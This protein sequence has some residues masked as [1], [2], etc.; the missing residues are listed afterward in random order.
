MNTVCRASIV[1]VVL[2]AAA[3]AG[4]AQPT[5][6]I[7]D[8]VPPG[9]PITQG[10]SEQ[11]QYQIGGT[12]NIV[13]VT[14]VRDDG[15]TVSIAN[16]D[17]TS[18][19]PFLIDLPM[20]TGVDRVTV[21]WIGTV[22]DTVTGE[23]AAGNRAATIVVDNV[24]PDPVNITSPS[25]PHTSYSATIELQG[26]ASNNPPAGGNTDLAETGGYLV[27]YV[28]ATGQ[29]VGGGIIRQDSTFLATVDMTGLTSDTMYTFNIHAVD[30][31]G[32]LGTTST[33]QLEYRLPP[34]PA[35]TNVTI[36]PPA[37]TLTNNPGVTVRG[38]VTGQ[39]P[40]FTVNVFV[41]GFI[42]SQI[43][44]LASGESFNHTLTLPGEGPHTISIQATNS[45][46][47][48]AVT[49]AQT[50]GTIT[51]DR[52]PPGAPTILSPD[53]NQSPYV[54][55]AATFTIRGIAA[56]R[57]SNTADAYTPAMLLAGPSGITFNPASPLPLNADGSFETVANLQNLG[58]GT[59]TITVTARD[60]AGNT[61]PQS[62][63][64]IV[65]VRD[66]TAPLV[67][68]IRV[69][70]VVAPQTNPEIYVGQR[71]VRVSV[72]VN[73]DMPTTPSST[74]TQTG[75]ST[76]PTGLSSSTLRFFD[77][78]Y[79][80]IPGH[81]GPVD[82][83]LSGG[84]DRAGNALT[85]S[86]PRLFIV[87]TVAPTVVSVTPTEGTS[88]SVSPDRIRIR[89][90]DPL[91][92]SN[93]ASGM[94]LASC[95]VTMSG[96]VGGSNAVVA[97][98][99]VPYDPVTLDFVP[100][101]P[102]VEEGVYRLAITAVDKV[103]NRSSTVTRT[104][105]F[106]T[107]PIRLT[108]QT[109]VTN[110]ADGAYVNAVT[111]PGTAASPFVEAFINDPQFNPATS[112]IRSRD[113]CRVPVDVPGTKTTTGPTNLTW[114]FKNPLATDGSQDGVYTIELDVKDFAG[115]LAP[116]YVTTYTY[117]T[118]VPAVSATFPANRE[119]VR[120]PLRIVDATM[121][122]PRVDFC[123]RN[124]GIDRTQ[125]LLDLWLTTP[126][127]YSGNTTTAPYQVPGTLRFI[128]VGDV[129]RV[130]LEIVNAQGNVTGLPTDGT[131]DGTYELR[132][133][134]VDRSGNRSGLTSVT[135][136]YDTQAPRMTVDALT[137][138]CTI[139]APLVEFGGTAQDNRGGSG[140]NR[141]EVSL[142]QVD[143]QGFPTQTPAYFDKLRAT[144]APL[145]LGP[146][147]P[148]PPQRTWTFS[149]ALSGL[150]TSTR[151][152]LLVRAFDEGGSFAEKRYI[153]T[154]LPS[155]LPAPQLSAP[156]AEASTSAQTVTFS[157][158]RVEGAG[159]Y[160]VR[161]TTPN[162]NEILKDTLKDVLSVSVNLAAWADG[163]GR[164]TW[165]VASK[166]C[167]G[168]VGAWSKN[169]V[170]V[171]DR[172]QPRVVAI[173]V[174]DPSPEAAGTVNEG[175]VR[176]TIRFTEPM[177]TTRPLT[178]I[179]A[180]QNSTAPA[181]TVTPMSFIGDTWTGRVIIPDAGTTGPDYNGLS[182][183]SVTG[184]RD[185]GGNAMLPPQEGFTVVEIDTGPF[186]KLAMFVNPI[187]EQ[188]VILVVKGTS[189]L[190]GPTERLVEPLTVIVR[191]TGQ[192][193][194]MPS[195][196]RIGPGA[197]RG[198]FFL[199]P[200]LAT[201]LEVQISGKDEQGNTSTRT[202]KLTVSRITVA[203]GGVVINQSRSMIVT[204][205]PGAVTQDKSIFLASASE[206]LADGAGNQ[207]GEGTAGELVMLA[208]LG[209]VEPQ[210]VAIPGG[211]DLLVD[212]NAVAPGTTDEI[213]RRAGLYRLD[214]DRWRWL[215]GRLDGA[216][217]TGRLDRTA[218]LAVMADTVAPRVVGLGEGAELRVARGEKLVVAVTDDGSGVDPLAVGATVDGRPVEAT[219]DAEAGALVVAPGSLTSGG[220]SLEVRAA[221]RSGNVTTASSRLVAPPAFGF[222]QAVAYP[223]P[224]RA[225]L[226]VRYRL[227]ADADRVS[228]SIHDAAGRRVAV[229]EGPTSSATEQTVDWNLVATNGR[230]VANGV[231]FGRLVAWSAGRSYRE[232]LKLAVLR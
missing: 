38:T 83:A 218:A 109:V 144:L 106:D 52:T 157:W 3:S 77:Y 155:A 138:G 119:T 100:A 26:N 13:N 178:V 186:F 9:L 130:L 133:E 204:A 149:G 194:Q 132:T 170:L 112:T 57:D 160:R 148:T 135:F 72:R 36:T 54:T 59:Y 212:L 140:I 193:D 101:V 115:N 31:A 123:R 165:A 108:P 202:T 222:S 203:G 185:L 95:E 33:I 146:F 211:L 93:T 142:Q 8:W 53:P 80:V 62:S 207:A 215:E 11:L 161:I 188:D 30:E 87:D 232:D 163:D 81:D 107:T 187:N 171:I 10:P 227:T 85:S 231:Y 2:L 89:F 118:R 12:T 154:V 229:I 196:Y 90:E 24:G 78:V 219:W 131:A 116:T 70:G 69:D 125:S 159:G 217:L 1:V 164:Y 199:D 75:Y 226:R 91:S 205:G 181:L 141:V 136:V 126:N 27:I 122:D 172:G 20:P 180:P 21:T 221:D 45:N 176:F 173:D 15:T 151:A 46:V 145:G 192:R 206:A 56:E 209:A 137:D 99:L 102:L 214:G 19:Q 223:N 28:P 183:L 197:F 179:L 29:T 216:T 156:A 17:P 74:I 220:A 134:A 111:M 25:I 167:T 58:D 105:I 158:T 32:N 47:P 84:R 224:A 39:V 195:M 201:D 34:P 76:L 14:F 68:E 228:L 225:Y 110:P 6:T 22:V 4:L 37:G 97:G 65:F 41:D 48:P 210:G 213:A 177:D 189:R 104:F 166:D 114:T 66:T 35:L 169:R 43:A 73:E 174:Y 143:T 49:S 64:Q 82:F 208:P 153:V 128:S 71:S 230:S 67:E 191:R 23:F 61:G 96:A 88:V 18:A 16:V 50:L 94:S 150:T 120:G 63:R 152:E 5:M 42:Q 121:K 162:G 129:E 124:S 127:T 168:K 147:D 139:T 92:G 184:G 113:Y 182:V 51:L 79:G 175:E 55:N 7:V 103:G 117:D 86:T 200:L 98:T 190:D 60:E 198:S 40:P 44:G